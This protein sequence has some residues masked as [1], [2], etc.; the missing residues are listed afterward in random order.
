MS[1]SL[2]TNLFHY[3]VSFISPILSQ[4]YFPLISSLKINVKP[5][6]SK[7]IILPYLFYNK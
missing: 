1:Y 3:S 6:L 2:A 7:I 4:I 5:I